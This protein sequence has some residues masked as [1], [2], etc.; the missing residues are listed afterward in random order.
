MSAVPYSPEH[1]LAI[2][3]SPRTVKSKLPGENISVKIVRD[4]ICTWVGRVQGVKIDVRLCKDRTGYYYWRVIG[5]HKMML[6]TLKFK[7][8][9]MIP[10]AEVELKSAKSP[11]DAKIYTYLIIGVHPPVSKDNQ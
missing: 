8:R 9:T 1:S 2:V 5:V 4:L 3:P 6:K 10:H 11:I 7:L